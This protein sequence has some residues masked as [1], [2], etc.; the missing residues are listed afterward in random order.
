MSRCVVALVAFVM[1]LLATLGSAPVRADDVPAGELYTPLHLSIY[2]PLELPNENCHVYGLSLG[3]VLVGLHTIEEHGRYLGEGSDTVIGLQIC[4]LMTFAKELRGLQVSSFAN[5]ARAMPWGLQVA[6]VL[7]Y[8]GGDMGCGLQ[9][10]A[11]WNRCESGAGLQLAVLN[12]ADKEFAGL[13]AGLFNFGGNL[14][15]SVQFGG[16]NPLIV[17]ILINYVCSSPGVDDMRGLQVG[18]VNKASDMYGIQCGLLWNHA[19]CAGGLQLG[20]INTAD[21]MAGFQVGLVNIIKESSVPFLPLI[22]AHF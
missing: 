8:I 19:K 6:G 17:I 11:G 5:N 15:E 3:V 14:S 21:S 22:N 18:L 10:A 4:G 16:L 1:P 12:E 7:N 9:V 13:Q 2:P 20:L